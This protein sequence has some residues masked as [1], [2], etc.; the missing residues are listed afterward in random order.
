[1]TRSSDAQGSGGSTVHQVGNNQVLSG[2]CIDDEVPC[3]K[4]NSMYKTWKEKKGRVCG[5]DKAQPGKFEV[6]ARGS[7]NSKVRIG[8]KPMKTKIVSF[9]FFF[10]VREIRIRGPMF[11][12]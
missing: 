7:V 4:K 3:L 11:C 9:F 10:S 1:M 6:T 5:Q 2:Y 8:A 12:C